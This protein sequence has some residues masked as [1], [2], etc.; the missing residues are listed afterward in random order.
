MPNQFFWDASAL[1]K[2]YAPESGT[3]LV[4]LLFSRVK[5]E[6][7]ISLSLA[8]SEVL[9][10]F[11]RKRNDGLITDA[12]FSQALAELRAEVLDSPFRLAPLE[13]RLVF[14]SHPL[15]VQH[16]L[17]ATDGLVLR[18]ALELRTALRRAGDDLVL[19]ASDQRLLRAADAEGLRAF[20]PET[21]SQSELELLM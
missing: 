18:A 14:A 10:V 6:R 5:L 15:I 20:N 3:Q 21:G 13:D 16:S 1:V 12:I 7:M 19:I 9:S 2:R 4:N 11:V 17:N 8:V